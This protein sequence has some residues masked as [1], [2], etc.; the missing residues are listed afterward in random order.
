MAAEPIKLYLTPP[1]PCPYLP[2]LDSVNLIADPSHPMD[3]WQYGRL[4]ARGFRRS[5]GHVYRPHCPNCQACVPVRIPVRRFRP[6]RSQRRCLRRNADLTAHSV[7][8]HL[9]D[10]YFDLYRRYLQQRHPGGGMDEPTP[11]SFEAFLMAPWS[12]TRFVEFR[13]RGRLLAVAVAD[14]LPDGF[15]AV[16][17]F[18]EPDETRR[19]L[20]T[21]AILWQVE[22]ARRRHLRHVYLGY[23]IADSPKMAYKIR[24]QPLEGY[25]HGQWRTLPD[26]RRSLDPRR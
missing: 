22:A 19:G 17:T 10:E 11:D 26:D 23:W 21:L 7:L 25:R 15:S 3:P 14:L 5:G 8:P 12:E 4:V 24:F 2:G 20:G 9:T 18:Y 13:H 16:Y 1:H 6:D